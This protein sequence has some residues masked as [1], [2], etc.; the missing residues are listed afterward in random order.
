MSDD[1]QQA[2]KYQLDAVAT[3]RKA[4]EKDKNENW[5]ARWP[6]APGTELEPVFWA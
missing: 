2:F 6:A 4:M 3:L 1:P 5:C